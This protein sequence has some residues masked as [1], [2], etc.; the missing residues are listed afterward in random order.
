MT[1]EIVFTAKAQQNL[2]DIVLKVYELS[3]DKPTAIGF[4][5]RLRNAEKRLEDFPAS[6][7][8]PIDRILLG[9]GYRYVIE[10]DY[11]IFYLHDDENRKVYIHHIVNGK[12]DY[13]RTIIRNI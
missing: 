8:L 10:G 2:N 6:G 3:N 1:Y 4:A 9:F 11:L 12:T 5:N 13:I 7:K